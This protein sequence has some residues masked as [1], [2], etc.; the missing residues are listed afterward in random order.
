MTDTTHTTIPE[1][2]AS[3]KALLE[4]VSSIKKVFNHLPTEA[5][6][7]AANLPCAAVSYFAPRTDN[8][9]IYHHF[10]VVLYFNARKD[11]AEATEAEVR[12]VTQAV[13]D[14]FTANKSLGG[15]VVNAFPTEG[16]QD[17]IVGDKRDSTRSKGVLHICM[18]L[19]VQTTLVRR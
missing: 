8:Y 16:H 17:V 6:L 10:L 19:N 7:A 18:F 13:F 3:L 14:A 2:A 9:Q 15:T 5:D 1:I 4:S 12:N 11:K